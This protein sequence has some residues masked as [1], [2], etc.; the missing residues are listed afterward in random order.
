MA[1]RSVAVDPRLVNMPTE[2]LDCRDLRHSWQRMAVGTKRRTA[3]EKLGQWES[4]R[5]CDRCGM[6]RTDLME[7]DTWMLLDRRYEAPEG[8]YLPKHERAQGRITREDVLAAV[9]VA[10]RETR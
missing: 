8:Y 9:Y 1:R 6:R 3:L 2:F 5:W 4:I 10:E 7:L